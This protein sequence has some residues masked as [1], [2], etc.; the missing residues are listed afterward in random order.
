LIVSLEEPLPGSLMDGLGL[1][2]G[3]LLAGDLAATVL[4]AGRDTGLGPV[5]L[6][7]AAAAGVD[8]R[9]FPAFDFRAGGRAFPRLEE[10]TPELPDPADR[11]RDRLERDHRCRPR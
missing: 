5:R 7:A 2:A 3:W 6:R 10:L 9:A 11:I 4:A 8:A 1:V